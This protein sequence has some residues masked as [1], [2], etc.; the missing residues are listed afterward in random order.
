[1]NMY[2]YVCWLKC[3]LKYNE[4][5]TEFIIGIVYIPPVASNFYNNDLYATFADEVSEISS[6]YE[7]VYLCGD[8]NAQT[9]NLAD[10]TSNDAFLSDFFRKMMNLF[11]FKS[12][13]CYAAT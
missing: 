12:R 1:M 11:V 7:H 5:I 4:N 6:K 8:F 9:G 2:E 10:Y 13:M 3:K